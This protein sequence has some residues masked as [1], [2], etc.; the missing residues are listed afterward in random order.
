MSSHILDRHNVRLSGRSDAPET[1][2]FTHGLCTDQGA[3]QA[4]AD[5]LGRDFRILVYDIAGAVPAT[6]AHYRDH[7]HRYL[8][9]AGYAADLLAVCDA[10]GLRGVVT[11]V[12]HSV[13][14]LASMLATIERPRAF[15]RLVMIGSSPCYVDRDGYTGGFTRADIDGIYQ[16]LSGSYDSTVPRIAALMTGE[17]AGGLTESFISTMRSIPQDLMLTTLCSVLQCDRRQDLRRVGLPTLLIQSTRDA[18]VPVEVARY[19]QQQIPASRLALIDASGHLPHVTATE[20]VVE[21]MR[22]FLCAAAP[23]G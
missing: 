8:N 4:V 18:F 19:M 15:R 11:L 22:A 6:Q 7:R 17:E 16:A 23:V 5:D 10:A 9:I 3:W 12:G 14:G 21:A 2:V 13:G 1:L 20:P